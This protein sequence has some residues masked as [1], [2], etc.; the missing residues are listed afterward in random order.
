MVKAVLRWVWDPIGVRGV[1][2][3]VGEYDDYAPA[4]VELLN[5]ASSV[6]EVAAYLASVETERMGLPSNRDKDEDVAALLNELHALV[7]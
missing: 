2:E 5:R 1:E 3:A 7:P 6:E 4:V